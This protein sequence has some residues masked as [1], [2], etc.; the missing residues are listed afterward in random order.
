M[1]VLA[2]GFRSSQYNCICILCNGNFSIEHLFFAVDCKRINCLSISLVTL[3]W[4]W[5]WKVWIYLLFL[6]IGTVF[7]PS[8]LTCPLTRLS[9]RVWKTLT[10]QQSWWFLNC[11]QLNWSHIEKNILLREG[12]KKKS[13]IA[14][15][16][17]EK[18]TQNCPPWSIQAIPREAQNWPSCNYYHRQ[19]PKVQTVIQQDN[20]SVPK[21][22]WSVHPYLRYGDLPDK[23]VASKY[24]PNSVA[25]L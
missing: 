16:K 22:T 1:P 2:I 8:L 6:G 15:V 9:T 23:N 11:L 24:T 17:L 13:L 18:E 3:Q 12:E 25:L 10:I 4:R 5:W 20:L 21:T 14:I 7:S 19:T